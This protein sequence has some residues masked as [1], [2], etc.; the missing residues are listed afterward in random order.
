MQ[1][2]LRKRDGTMKTKELIEKLRE[3][4]PHYKISQLDILLNEAADRLEELD[5]RLDIVF[6][7]MNNDWGNQYG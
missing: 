2:F 3:R 7:N 4:A 5:E 6:S 1:K